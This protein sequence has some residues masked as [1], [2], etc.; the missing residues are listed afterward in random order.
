MYE[1]IGGW[2][3]HSTDTRKALGS[4]P[5]A[6]TKTQNRELLLDFLLC[7]SRRY[8]SAFPNAET[9]ETG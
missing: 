3:E 2:L 5:R 1:P 4:N 6:R 7:A 8:V 9:T